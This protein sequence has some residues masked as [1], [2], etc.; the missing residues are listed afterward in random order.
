MTPLARTALILGLSLT[1]CA[2]APTGPVLGS[3]QGE[4]PGP[5][6]ST[7]EIVSLTLYGT[8]GATSGR[9]AISTQIQ[10]TLFGLDTSL[11]SW[12]GTW[13][14]EAKDYHGQKQSII[15]LH[16][17]LSSEINQYALASNGWLE[18]TSAYVGRRLTQGEIAL[19]SLRPLP[20]NTRAAID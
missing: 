15:Y 1:S 2:A 17:A 6:P 20:R 12:S 13:T 7:P 5:W 4:P 8:P 19:Y 18:P 14:R 3:W 10:G 16:D 9:Y 11:S